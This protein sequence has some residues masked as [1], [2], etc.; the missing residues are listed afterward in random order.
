VQLVSGT[1]KLLTKSGSGQGEASAS[2]VVEV[3]GKEV[4]GEL[5]AADGGLVGPPAAS[6]S[7]S[8]FAAHHSRG[9]RSG[10]RVDRLV[11][12]EVFR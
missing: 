5:T 9:C 12:V 1:F 11:G 7:P 4:A 8:S 2:V 10:W 6:G 3:A